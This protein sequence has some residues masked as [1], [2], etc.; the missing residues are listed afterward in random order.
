MM[1]GMKKV[2]FMT[3]EQDRFHQDV[4]SLIADL[5]TPDYMTD[6]YADI[7][8]PSLI[9]LRSVFRVDKSYLGNYLGRTLHDNRSLTQGKTVL[10]LGCGCGFLG[11]ICALNGA[12][13]IHFSDVN[14]AAVKNS[15]L[16]GLLLGVGRASFSIGDL[17]DNIP[18]RKKFD[19]IVFNPP[20][21]TGVP[22]NDSEAAFIREDRV[23]LDFY[24]LF[25]DYL[26]KGGAVIIPGSTRFDGD[27][28][29]KN[30]AGRYNLEYKLI[31]EEQETDG[32]SKYIIIFK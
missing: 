32:N 13:R 8:I 23:I 29:P 5:D 15:R 22:S 11:L 27:M 9:V 12:K 20:S 25:P 19:L 24:R 1:F 10:D 16:N 4:K 30:M 6:V 3:Q 21:I 17:F 18:R 28:S 31:A 14:P 7:G 26:K 2:S